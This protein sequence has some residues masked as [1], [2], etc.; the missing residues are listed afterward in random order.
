MPKKKQA[1]E[2]VAGL[3]SDE[4]MEGIKRYGQALGGQ[5]TDFDEE[6]EKHLAG[7]EA[8]FAKMRAAQT[9]GASVPVAPT[10]IQQ[11]KVKQTDTLQQQADVQGQAAAQAAQAAQA[12]GSGILPS[13]NAPAAQQAP[14]GKAPPPPPQ[15]QM[16]APPPAPGG[17]PAAPEAPPEEE[18]GA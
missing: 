18:Q 16:Q 5:P 8:H 14:S 10:P 3:F 11:Q 12:Q 13:D 4:E 15:A 7:H 9:G 17:P 6:V 1:P 2:D